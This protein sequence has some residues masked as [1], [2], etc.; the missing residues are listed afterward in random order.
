[1]SSASAARDTFGS[2]GHSGHSGGW[3]EEQILRGDETAPLLRRRSGDMLEEVW[4]GHCGPEMV[5][6]AGL[7]RRAQQQSRVEVVTAL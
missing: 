4:V 1:M 7:D 3:W 5:P 2:C 6:F